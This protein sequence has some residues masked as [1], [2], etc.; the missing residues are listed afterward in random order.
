MTIKLF[1]VE[2]SGKGN[3]DYLQTVETP[4]VERALI[5]SFPEIQVASKRFD[6]FAQINTTAV[7]Q[8]Y[9]IGTNANAR[10]AGSWEDGQLARE[11]QFYA[12]KGCWVRF[13]SSGALPQF[14]PEG[15]PLRFYRRVQAFYVYQDTQAGIL[16][17]WIDG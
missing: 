5:V 2:T 7:Q 4:S 9:I 11:I 1:V 8:E 6:D 14:I 13:N 3:P 12:T 16:Y 17:A 15:M 10:I